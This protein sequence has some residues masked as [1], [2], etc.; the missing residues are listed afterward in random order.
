MKI[1]LF[2]KPASGK[3]TQAEKL[4][5]EYGLTHVSTGNL[6]RDNVKRQTPLG[7]KVE[8]LMT[9][10]ELI[11]D[12][13]VL[14]ILTDY[15]S[16]HPDN[17]LFDGFPR[18]I[19]QAE[20]LSEIMTID[21]VVDIDVPDE[22]VIKRITSRRVCDKGHTYSLLFKPP[23]HEGLCDVDGLP[24]IQREDDTEGVMTRRLDEYNKQTL[25]LLDFYKSIVKKIDGSKPIDEVTTLA[26]G[27]LEMY[28]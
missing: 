5:E 7:K 1:I 28:K 22:D 9:T 23:K 16:H 3:G 12:E 8:T 24:L 17:V 27:V 25:P 21:V 2:G 26:R 13:I 11:S 6:L 20:R 19:H 14:E 15:L 10:G 18:T 4:C